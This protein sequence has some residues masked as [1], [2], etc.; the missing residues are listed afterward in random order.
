MR[1]YRKLPGAAAEARPSAELLEARVHGLSVAAHYGERKETNRRHPMLSYVPR[2][3][4]LAR[5]SPSLLHLRY[6]R[7]SRR[8]RSSGFES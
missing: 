1:K 4:K 2:E 3:K 6:V 7:D 8:R 5:E